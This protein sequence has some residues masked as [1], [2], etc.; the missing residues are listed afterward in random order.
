MNE[1][2]II[3]KALD[4]LK[5]NTNI[6]G[7][8]QSF[9]ENKKEDSKLFLEVGNT[10]LEYLTTIKKELRLQQIPQLIDGTKKGN[11]KL[12]IVATR[13]FPKVKEELRQ[14]NMAYLEANG[15]IF[16]K[17]NDTLIWI[18]ANKPLEQDTKT[19]TRAFTKT[20]LRVVYQFLIDE[21][22]IN[23]P[24]R[25]ISEQTGT[26]IGNVTNIIKGLLQ[27]GFL[28]PIAKNQYK[29]S[30]K[31]KL[32]DKWAIAY[33]EK[34]KDSLRIGTFRFLKEADFINWEKL[35]LNND[36]T[37]WG[38]EPAGDLLTNFLKPAELT[39]YTTETRNE[40]IKNYKLIPDEKGNVKVYQK[41]W[42]DNENNKENWVDPLLIYVDL[43][44]ENDRRCTETAK[45]I[46]D[47]YL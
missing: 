21:Q 31:E 41:F 47:E 27:E 39:L 13:L 29:I 5:A 25:Q 19:T 15:N 8:W 26:G 9:A 37:W 38:G 24:Y 44:N 46:Y 10:K 3:H 20:G 33:G 34:L 18:D 11:S 2:Q 1:E 16:L 40:I 12:M 43:M 17:S 14:N 4:A 7:K 23:K 32:L 22:W 6:K 35:Q 45:K 30:N 42:N 36:K 28:L